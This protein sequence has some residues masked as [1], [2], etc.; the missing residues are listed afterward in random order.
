MTHISKYQLNITQ[1]NEK[2]AFEIVYWS[3]QIII[4]IYNFC[5]V[6]CFVEYKRTIVHQIVM[7]V[8]DYIYL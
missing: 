4:N 7:Q 5:F 6:F 8:C 3:Q 2:L 1:K